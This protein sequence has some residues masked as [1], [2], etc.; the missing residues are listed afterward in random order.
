MKKLK[1]LVTVTMVLALTLSMPFHALA[2]ENKSKSNVGPV[3][4]PSNEYLGIKV[5]TNNGRFN[6]GS[7]MTNNKF[8][9]S[10]DWNDLSD[11]PGTSFT[12][13][14]VDGGTQIFGD[15]IGQF[16]QQPTDD[17][18]DLSNTTIWQY[19]K[20]KVTQFLQIVDNP[21]TGRKDT[22]MYKYIVTNTDTAAH[23]V[24]LRVM[25]DTMLGDTDGAPFRLPGVGSVTSEK[26]LDGSAIPDFWQA[27]KDFSNL[28]IMSEGI[29]RGADA[30]PPDRLSFGYWPRLSSSLWD[31]TVDTNQSITEDSALAMWWNETS[32]APG[33][34]RDYVTYYGLGTVS[35]TADLSLT[36]PSSLSKVNGQWSPNPFTITAYI[37][38]N[39]A[40]AESNVQANLTLPQGLSLAEGETLTHNID[41]IPSGTSTQTSWKVVPES[42]GDYTYSVSVNGKT[43]SKQ[44][45]VPDIIPPTLTD[46]V[47]GGLYN[48]PQTVT[49]SASEPSTVYY[50]TDGSDPNINSTKYTEPL[51]INKDTVLKFFAVDA[52]GNASAISTESYTID[53]I[54]PVLS[55]SG[56]KD[57]GFYNTDVTPSISL[58]DPKATLTM[59]LNGKPYDGS[60]ISQGGEYDLVINAVDTAGNIATPIEVKFTIKKTPPV[61]TV[62]GIKDGQSIKD[63]ANISFSSND[64]G[65]I[66]ATLD[67]KAYSSGVIT[68]LGK[69]ILIITDTDLAGNVT[70]KTISF[71]VISGATPDETPIATPSVLPQTGFDIDLTTCIFTGTL[72][73]AL[74]LLI[75]TK[76]LKLER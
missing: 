48:K 16:I 74:G 33:Q 14:K 47:K 58:N 17:G 6:S 53:V 67:G 43:V 2:A 18:A 31:Y 55:L 28:N 44:I 75:L 11:S 54:S 20:I 8:S 66:S 26:E 38:N 72:F 10:Y 22:G 15:T 1:K 50:T 63:K 29:L 49:L 76:G 34:S 71:S 35:G 7:N 13:L 70:T 65:Q 24:G 59:T 42:Q 3:A 45:V 21:Y 37:G 36:G 40:D 57:G 73:L 39:T 25:I 51:V 60:K 56:I 62:T 27:F 64:K 68:S 9:I 46:N 12:T 32:L 41:L 4:D 69:H 30:T 5:N 52:A 23:N 19:G 61:I